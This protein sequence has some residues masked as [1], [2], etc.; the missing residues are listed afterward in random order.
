MNDREMAALHDSKVQCT[1]AK[2]C[3][4]ERRYKQ[5]HI[6]HMLSAKIVVFQIDT[7]SMLP[8][9]IVILLTADN[10]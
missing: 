7:R 2:L 9:T 10:N 1:Y 3:S 8:I 6:I 4:T 5:L